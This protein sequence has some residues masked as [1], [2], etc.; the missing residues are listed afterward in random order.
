MTDFIAITFYKKSRPLIELS[1]TD[2]MPIAGAYF[3]RVIGVK[4]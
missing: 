4:S 3:C 2:A 1:Q